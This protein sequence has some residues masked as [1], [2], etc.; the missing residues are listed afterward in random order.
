MSGSECGSDVEGGSDSSSIHT[1]PSQNSFAS[2]STA[3]RNFG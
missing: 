2:K 1:L 3:A